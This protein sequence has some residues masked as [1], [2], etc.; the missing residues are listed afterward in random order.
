MAKAW[1]EMS[2]SG[3]EKYKAPPSECNESRELSHEERKKLIV[4]I[5]KR[6]QEDVCCSMMFTC[7][8][9]I[10]CG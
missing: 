9:V 10:W 1:R 3:K 8:L 7:C 6:H 4:Q 2:D 5:A